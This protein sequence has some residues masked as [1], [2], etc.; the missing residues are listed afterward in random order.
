[1]TSLCA[2]STDFVSLPC[3]ISISF[4][5]CLQ[6]WLWFWSCIYS[7]ARR[8]PRMQCRLEHVVA[9]PVGAST[10]SG[11]RGCLMTRLCAT[12]HFVLLSFFALS[13]SC[14]SPSRRRPIQDFHQMRCQ[15]P[16]HPRR[17]RVP[18]HP[19]TLVM[20]SQKDEIIRKTLQAGGFAN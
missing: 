15:L 4:L 8:L 18:D 17:H 6:F 10:P 3:C 12:R 11:A 14:A 9:A 5:L 20:G 7:T 13:K 1:M 19:P 2:V 16:S